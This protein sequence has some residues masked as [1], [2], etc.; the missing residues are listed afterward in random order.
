MSPLKR[1]IRTCSQSKS[2]FSY[3]FKPLPPFFCEFDFC[4]ANFFY[5]ST[6]VP[7][8]QCQFFPFTAAP[9]VPYSSTLHPPHLPCLPSPIP[10]HHPLA[11]TYPST[12]FICTHK[13]HH[14]CASERKSDQERRLTISQ[15][16]K[17]TCSSRFLAWSHT[18]IRV[19]CYNSYASIPTTTCI[20]PQ[21]AK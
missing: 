2:A 11:A 1:K 9:P 7:L 18:E 5:L 17:I 6:V 13:V 16:K 21:L 14:A 19:A 8:Q 12:L 3:V 10:H 15:K 20:T 4:S